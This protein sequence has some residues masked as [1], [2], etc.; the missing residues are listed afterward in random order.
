MY[1]AVIFDMDGLLIDTEPISY[2]VIGNL[3]KSFGEDFSMAEYTAHYSGKTEV[4]NTAAIIARYGLSLSQAEVMAKTDALERELLSGG[5]PLKPGA[6]ALLAHL[7]ARGI[8]TAIA[9]SST[10]ERAIKLLDQHNLRPSF[11]AFVFGDEIRHGKPAPD[12]FLLAAEKLAAP[13]P[14]C[15]VL[16]DSEAGIRAAHAAGIPVICVPD[17]KMPGEESRKLLLAQCESLNE[18][19]AYFP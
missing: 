5:A 15:L 19:A 3:L 11:D 6:K 13:P 14:E 7:R 4:Q 2:Q 18:V 16:E 9:T 1:H 10:R 17:L 12:V 8:K